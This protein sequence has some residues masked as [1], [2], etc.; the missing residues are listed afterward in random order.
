MGGV[1][2][3]EAQSVWL[4]SSSAACAPG[5]NSECMQMASLVQGT[6]E[7]EIEEREGWMASVARRFLPLQ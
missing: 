5:E 1:E 4:L 2:G 7:D 3:G 6:H